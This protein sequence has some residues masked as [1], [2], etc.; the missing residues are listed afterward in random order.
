MVVPYGFAS[1]GLQLVGNVFREDQMFQVAYAYEQTTGW[2]K[3][4]PKL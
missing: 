1:N 3:E 4:G 2:H